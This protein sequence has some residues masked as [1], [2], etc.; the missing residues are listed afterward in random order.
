MPRKQSIAGRRKS[1]PTLI[2]L[3]NQANKQLCKLERSGEYGKYA[4]KE[5]IRTAKESPK[6]NYRRKGYKKI[7]ISK[8]ARMKPI[9]QRALAKQLMQFL[10]S[11]LS[12]AHNIKKIRAETRKKVKA[13]LQGLRDKELTNEDIDEFYELTHDEDFRYLADKIGDSDLYVLLSEVKESGGDEEDLLEKL[14]Q[15]MIFSNSSDAADR[16][17]K[18]YNKWAK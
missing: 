13:R 14:R 5:L 17:K 15:F 8:R 18:L 9:E 12:K 16:A 1:A 6:L 4:S 3:V 2:T 7:T 11:K 10:S